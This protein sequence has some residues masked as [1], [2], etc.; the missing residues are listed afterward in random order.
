MLTYYEPQV[1]YSYRMGD[2][3]YTG[4]KINKLDL[5]Y[6]DRNT[7]EG[8]LREFPIGSIHSALVDPEHPSEAVLEDLPLD[9]TFWVPLLFG[10]AA[11]GLFQ[12]IAYL[13]RGKSG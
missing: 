8:R 5:V 3:E 10:L 1:R 6:G 11:V 7:A 12:T 4:T 9:A 2:A 13:L